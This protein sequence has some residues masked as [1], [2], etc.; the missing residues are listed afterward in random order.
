MAL[1]HCSGR[2]IYLDITLSNSSLI[3]MHVATV[4]MKIINLLHTLVTRPSIRHSERSAPSKKQTATAWAALALAEL[5]AAVA[6]HAG[7]APDQR[8]ST[9][10]RRKVV[11]TSG[12][13]GVEIAASF[14]RHILCCVSFLI[15]PL[16]A[17]KSKQANQF[18]RLAL[19][20]GAI[21]VHGV[22]YCNTTLKH[23]VS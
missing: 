14:N 23:C 19:L 3:M 12:V 20:I 6:F 17:Q 5:L 1:T 2:F 11:P 18:V 16:V 22:E 8:H 4:L 7:W 15:L 21:A 9:P 13:R 10:L